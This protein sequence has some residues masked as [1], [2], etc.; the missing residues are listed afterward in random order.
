MFV[1]LKTTNLQ[2]T[3]LPGMKE[4]K[5]NKY[6]SSFTMNKLCTIQNMYFNG[7]KK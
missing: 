4:E 5:E 2:K 7:I 6:L 1:K 3:L